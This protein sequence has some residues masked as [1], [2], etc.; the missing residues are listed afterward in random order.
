MYARKDH[1]ATCW[2]QTKLKQR[3][4]E[5]EEAWME[6]LETWK[7]C[8]PSLRRCPD[9]GAACCCRAMDG[10]LLAGLADPA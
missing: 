7:A 8:K 4:G 1:C 6:A 2:R 5:L 10:H 9:G 3:E